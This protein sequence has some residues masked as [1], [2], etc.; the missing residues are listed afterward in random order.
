MASWAGH[1]EDRAGRGSVRRYSSFISVAPTALEAINA[2]L[3]RVEEL[4][5]VLEERAS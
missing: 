1:S 4:A 5:D 3:R 2:E